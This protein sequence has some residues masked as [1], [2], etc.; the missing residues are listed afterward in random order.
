MNNASHLKDKLVRLIEQIMSNRRFA[1][2]GTLSVIGIVA[3]CLAFMASFII[4]S[5]ITSLWPFPFFA[6]LS[7]LL[8]GPY[9]WWY[10]I[11]KPRRLTVKQ[12]IRV[13][14][15]GGL[16][17]HPLAWLL[18]VLPGVQTAH[19]EYYLGAAL[20]SSLASLILVGWLTALIGG[21]AGAVA[22][23]L[24][25]NCGCQQRWYATN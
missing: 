19:F 5:L 3:A 14:V 25:I 8:L 10:S 17:A 24:Q 22:A 4:A 23:K 21:L 9:L 1:I 18:A 6:G 13:G 15:L 20:Y 16:I 11:M 2:L 12:G 7:A